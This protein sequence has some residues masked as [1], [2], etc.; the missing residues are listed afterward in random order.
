MGS[1]T[2]TTLIAELQLLAYST[3]EYTILKY[4]VLDSI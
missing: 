1:T 2:P 3:T 4:Q